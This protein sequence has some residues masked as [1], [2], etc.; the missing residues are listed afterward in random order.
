[1]SEAIQRRSF[2]QLGLAASAAAI[3]PRGA[4][5]QSAMG[6]QKPAHSE[7]A[8]PSTPIRTTQLYDNLWLLQ[9]AGGNMAV[10]SGGEGRIVI[11]SSFA[12][13]VPHILQALAGLGQ[14]AAFALINTHW[15][16][17]H[18]G[19]NQAFHA[20]GF[21]IIAHQKTRERLSVPVEMKI[22]HR[23]TA[24]QPAAALPT[25]TFEQSLRIWRN[26][27]EVELAHF[28]PAHT[29]SDISIHF[30]KA[31]V[32]HVGDIWFNGMYPF[33][34]ESTGGK[35]GG[36]IRAVEQALA[37]A[38]SSTKIIPGHG[39]LGN[40]DD[41]AKYGSMLAEVRERVAKLKAGGL[42][43]QEAVAKK[44]TASLDAAWGKGM[45]SGDQI[46]GIAYR[47]L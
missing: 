42:S 36:M 5:A 41:L 20:A 45:M 15:H 26:G 43:E 34:D 46:A 8:E 22:F 11:D 38:D 25:V 13:A 21:T 44:P 12:S 14:E 19:G 16:P 7:N 6:A 33:I 23:T 18:T 28:E 31:N 40:K 3:F 35:I 47:T 29:D 17:D 27:D 1:M 30:K 37:V 24:A 39:P 4:S 9:G 32:L 2:L 10:Q